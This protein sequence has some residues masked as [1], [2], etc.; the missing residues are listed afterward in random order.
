MYNVEMGK[1]EILLLSAICYL[2]CCKELE[3]QRNFADVALYF[4]SF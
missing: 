1:Q 4:S 3:K 2:E